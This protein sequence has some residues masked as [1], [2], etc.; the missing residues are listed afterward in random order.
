MRTEAL[1]TSARAFKTRSRPHL[2]LWL[3]RALL[4]FAIILVLLPLI[5]QLGISFK[6]EQDIFAS[7]LSPISLSP[8]LE[9]YR[10]VF[11]SVPVGRYALNSLLFATAVTLGQILVSILAAYSL[12]LL[13]P[14]GT[15]LAFGLIV[16]SLMVPF[17]VTYLPNY[18]SLASW[19]LLNSFAG[20]CLPMMASGYGAFLLYGHFSSFPRSIL[21]A[22][23][24]DGA[25]RAQTLW[26]VVVPAHRA[27]LTA[28]AVTVFIQTWNQYVWPLLVMKR[29]E[30]Y[31]LTVA[32]Q[33]F[34]GGEG[35]NAWGPMMAVGVLAS[36][37]TM[38]LYLLMRRGVLSTFADGAVK[39]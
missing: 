3:A 14:S 8:T 7:P 18:L 2:G 32:V 15:R 23:Q 6:P 29:P 20:L 35:M 10:R 4:W 33:S 26:R 9:H 34:A 37:P 5:Y 12:A 28:L 19:G 30:N 17:V 25:S 16:L 36:L 22:A 21:E 27:P 31:T 38:A 24:V 13:R 11:S 39:G 1:K